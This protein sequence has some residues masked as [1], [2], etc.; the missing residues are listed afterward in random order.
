MEGTALR[1]TTNPG[2]TKDRRR[3]SGGDLPP[4]GLRLRLAGVGA[5]PPP[6]RAS[7][8]RRD[9]KRR[10]RGTRNFTKRRWEGKKVRRWGGAKGACSHLPTSSPSHLFVKPAKRA[11]S[12]AAKAA[13]RVRRQEA[14]PSGAMRC[15]ARG[16]TKSQA[17]VRRIASRLRSNPPRQPTAFVVARRAF[18]QNSLKSPQFARRGP[19]WYNF[20]PWMEMSDETSWKTQNL[21]G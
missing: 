16:E 19:F 7:S 3:R 2:A 17:P 20:K 21:A 12:C 9:T 8:P 13:F 14:A 11:F 6:F 1:A 18:P 15:G 4:P 10:L 5:S